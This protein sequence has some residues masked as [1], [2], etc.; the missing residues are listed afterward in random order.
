MMS[1]SPALEKCHVCGHRYDPQKKK[2][3]KWTGKGP[4]PKLGQWRINLS[5]HKVHRRVFYK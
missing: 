4:K 2:Y 1:L 3:I 5:G